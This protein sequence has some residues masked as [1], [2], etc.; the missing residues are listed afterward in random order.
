MVL[1]SGGL[2]V[3][4]SIKTFQEL[5]YERRMRRIFKEDGKTLVIGLDHGT[6]L[7]VLPGLEDL[8]KISSDYLHAG[9]DALL[10]GPRASLAAAS[11]LSKY[12]NSSYWIR[13]NRT[14]IFDAVQPHKSTTSMVAEVEDAIRLDADAVVV[15]YVRD[16]NGG[17]TFADYEE[18]LAQVAVKCREFGLPLC[19]EAF[20]IGNKSEQE[21]I[22]TARIAYELGADILKINHPGNNASLSKILANVDVPVLLAGGSQATDNKGFL[23][24]MSASMELGVRGLVIGRNIWQ[25][26]DPLA[27]IR[28]LQEVVHG[29]DFAISK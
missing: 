12:T 23:E 1:K 18:Q 15:W 21:E 28:D 4:H 25:A 26:E 6:S 24:L 10:L 3:Q 29:K 13:L 19:V 14:N 9:A 5:G 27:A 7:G 2:N 16:V 17:E 8:G 22:N 20:T 11:S